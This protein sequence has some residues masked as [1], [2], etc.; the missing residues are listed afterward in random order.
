MHKEQEM[1]SRYRARVKSLMKKVEYDNL[2]QKIWKSEL[3][4]KPIRTR[5]FFEAC[6]GNSCP[7]SDSIIEE[8]TM[9]LRDL[10]GINSKNSNVSST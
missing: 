9:L 5:R 8:K 10:Y 3:K 2:R 6:C 1:I 4:N 7:F